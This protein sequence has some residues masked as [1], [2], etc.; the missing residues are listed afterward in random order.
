MTEEKMNQEELLAV[1]DDVLRGL[2]GAFEDQ[3]D[4]TVAIEI[5]RNGKV[6]FSFD[7]R[8]LTEKQY[9][10]LQDQATKFKK[11]K[12]LGGVKIAEETDITRFRSL[13]IYHATAEE[14]RK[15]LWNNKEAWRALNVVNG[16]DLIDKVLKAGE[17]KA[18]IDKIDEISGYNDETDEIIKNSS[19]QEES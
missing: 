19:K 7:I 12:N 15:K 17:K 10:D 11:A 13:L 5:A 2:L 6:Y 3:Q 4:D 18:I 14:D 16:P 9:Q 8:G 1:E